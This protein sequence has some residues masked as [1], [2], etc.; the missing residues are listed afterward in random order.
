MPL[1][2]GDMCPI[3]IDVVSPATLANPPLQPPSIEE[4]QHYEH[5]KLDLWP[6]EDEDADDPD[7]E[8]Y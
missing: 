8:E 4:S 1:V 5:D 6:Q 3:A 2:N 7:E